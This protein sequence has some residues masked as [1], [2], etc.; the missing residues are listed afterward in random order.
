MKLQSWNLV[1]HKVCMGH[2]RVD[3]V[4]DDQY[5]LLSDCFPELSAKANEGSP[6]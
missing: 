6:Y 4:R 5:K 1:E 2:F 3:S